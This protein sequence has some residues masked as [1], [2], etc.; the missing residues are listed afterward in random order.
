MFPKTMP[1]PP[2]LWYG[3]SNGTAAAGLLLGP[4]AACCK[5]LLAAPPAPLTLPAAPSLPHTRL[6]GRHAPD[7]TLEQLARG[8]A[9]QAH[10]DKPVALLAEQA[11][12]GVQQ[13]DR[14][15]L[16]LALRVHPRPETGLEDWDGGVAA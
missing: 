14:E 2:H 15:L 5:P 13:R 3:S 16:R 4:S 10:Q 12:A 6:G 8:S 7:H 11:A 9:G 1:Q